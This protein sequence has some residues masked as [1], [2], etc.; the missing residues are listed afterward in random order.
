MTKHEIHDARI[1]SVS[2]L[3]DERM[4][5]LFEQADDRDPAAMTV[6]ESEFVVTYCARCSNPKNQENIRTA[7][8]LLAYL[9]AHKHWSP[10]EMANMN[11]EINTTRGVAAQII[12]HRSFAYQEFSQRYS[13]VTS[14]PEIQLPRLRRQDSTNKQASHDDLD[15]AF[16]ELANEK[17]VD[18]YAH[19]RDVYDWLIANEVAKECARAVL[20]IGSPTRLYMNGSI[21][22]WI[23]YIQIRTG[24]ET[25]LE[26]RMIADD[27]KGIFQKE[28][29]TIYEAAFT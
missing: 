14:L 29:P 3:A 13:N 6:E 12:R 5:E 1:V 25:Q 16:V 19:S 15:P 20:P 11:V 23:H 28:F 22:S 8:R 26:H 17:I 4:I 10:F 21:R 27:I 18:L 9:M 2:K 24:L 7:P